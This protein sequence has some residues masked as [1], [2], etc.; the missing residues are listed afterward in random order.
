MS[1]ACSRCYVT[2]TAY[3]CE[4]TSHNNRRDDAGGVLCESAPR[5]YGERPCSV[6]RV[7]AVQ[8]RVQLWSVNQLATEAEESELFKFVT[9]K[10]LV[11]TLQR[12][13]LCGKL[14]P[15]KD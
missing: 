3:A 5:L 4:V 1:D 2:P 11:R 10:R 14:L 6:Q 8:L 7:S 15:S 13:S 12:K 9:R